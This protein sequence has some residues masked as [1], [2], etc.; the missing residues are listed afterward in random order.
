MLVARRGF[1]ALP[2]FLEPY[3]VD[4]KAQVRAEAE[5]GADAAVR[6]W[7]YAALGASAVALLVGIVAV[8]RR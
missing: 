1:G 5:A 4:L 2:D 3:L 8:A 7:V 6:P